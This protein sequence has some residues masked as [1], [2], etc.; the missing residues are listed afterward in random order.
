MSIKKDL[1]NFIHG[2]ILQ[3]MLTLCAFF[4]FGIYVYI[5][6]N[7]IIY[8]LNFMSGLTF[9]ILYF[10]P[11]LINSIILLLDY[12]GKIS[13]KIGNFLSLT[14]IPV[15]FIYLLIVTFIVGVKETASPITNYK[16]YEK[17]YNANNILMREF[18]NKVPTKAEDIN[19]YYEPGLLQGITIMKL[20]YKID[21]E[22]I[23]KYVKEY[24]Q[25]AK[26]IG[27]INDGEY[28]WFLKMLTLNED[29]TIYY[30]YTDDNK[31][32]LAAINE[33][34]NKVIFSYSY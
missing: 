32:S 9:F 18:P 14:L 3:F 26:K 13:H 17:K 33:K 34:N 8:Y 7:D 30:L 21:K 28:D 12:K 27:Y 5:Y 23:D 1:V 2:R 20:S 31:C 16:F 11:F 4:I 19:F 15:I 6:F 24:K 25:K 10:I 22:T 29:Y